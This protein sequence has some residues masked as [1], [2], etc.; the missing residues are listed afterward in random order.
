MCDPRYT[1][2]IPC[3]DK[4]LN[5]QMKLHLNLSLMEHYERHCPDADHRLNCLIPPPPN[6]KV[7]VHPCICCSLYHGA[8]ES[9]R[10]WDIES[11]LHL[12]LMP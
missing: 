10:V 1:E 4:N 7:L 12:P 8:V 9:W 5:R 2:L 3:L 11:L 6:Y